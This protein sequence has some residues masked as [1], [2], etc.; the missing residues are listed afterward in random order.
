[1]PY[2]VEVKTNIET[3]KTNLFCYFS[4]FQLVQFS[5]KTR[6]IPHRAAVIS[7]HR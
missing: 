1:M 3:G 7:N 4:A 6:N 5:S 2:L